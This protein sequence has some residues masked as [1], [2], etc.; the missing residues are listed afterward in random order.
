MKAILAAAAA[1]AIASG[2][3]LN[4]NQVQAQTPAPAAQCA[5]TPTQA[6]DGN[7]EALFLAEAATN[8]ETVEVKF[9]CAANGTA[10]WSGTDREHGYRFMTVRDANGKLIEAESLM[11]SELG[12]IL[13]GHFVDPQGRTI[14]QSWFTDHINPSTFELTKWSLSA[15]VVTNADG[16]REANFF[17]VPFDH[18]SWATPAYVERRLPDGTYSVQHFRDGCLTNNFT[19]K[20][21]LGDSVPAPMPPGDCRSNERQLASGVIEGGW[22]S[23][24]P[25][26]SDWLEPLRYNGLK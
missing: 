14:F 8:N 22:V 23:M 25:M 9:T 2:V 15:V 12:W 18:G 19:K 4:S 3:V 11:T 13:M 24:P 16:T 5:P 17:Y 10:H 6:D 26:D 1:L 21:E 20:T 7:L